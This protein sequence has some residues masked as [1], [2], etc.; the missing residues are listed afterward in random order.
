MQPHNTEERMKTAE[1]LHV[2]KDEMAVE[3]TFETSRSKEIKS[4]IHAAPDRKRRTKLRQL[5]AKDV[6]AVFAEGPGAINSLRDV[7]VLVARP[8][9]VT[10]H[11]PYR[12]RCDVCM[13][14]ENASDRTPSTSPCL[15]LQHPCMITTNDAC[16]PPRQV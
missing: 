15:L 2:E 13:D 3:K 16:P 7:Q 5:D 14:P 8:L 10:V 6:D 1:H 11:V 9:D 4:R 12:A